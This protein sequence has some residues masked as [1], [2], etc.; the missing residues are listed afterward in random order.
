MNNQPTI[1]FP[2]VDTAFSAVMV[3]ALAVGCALLV[4]AQGIRAV[5]A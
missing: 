3:A 4:V 1:S 2:S 5:V